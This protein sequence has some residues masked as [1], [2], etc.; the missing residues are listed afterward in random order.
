MFTYENVQK[1][2]KKKILSKKLIGERLDSKFEGIPHTSLPIVWS[3]SH[4][5]DIDQE[6]TINNF[7]LVLIERGFHN[8]TVTSDNIIVR[9]PN[10]PD[11]YKITIV[12]N[13]NNG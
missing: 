4:D 1:R 12:I 5:C 7:R 2:M 11:E 13:E 8:A 9:S 3:F 6:E 10:V